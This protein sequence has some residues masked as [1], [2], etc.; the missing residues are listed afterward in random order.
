M[1]NNTSIP[2]SLK[3]QTHKSRNCQFPSHRYCIVC[4]YIKTFY[5]VMDSSDL[6]TYNVKSAKMCTFKTFRQYRYNKLIGQD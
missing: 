5:G 6:F 4:M 3:L 2:I 1:T